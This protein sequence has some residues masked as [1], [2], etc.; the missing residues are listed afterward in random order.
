[1]NVSQTDHIILIYVRFYMN[2]ALNQGS[3]LNKL[4]VFHFIL[5]QGIRKQ[6]IDLRK[7]SKLLG[8][9]Y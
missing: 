1:M 9:F 5:D 2:F 7:R 4:R 6:M 8:K 3:T